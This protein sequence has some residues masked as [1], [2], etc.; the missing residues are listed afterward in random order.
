[1]DR[2]VGQP[3]EQTVDDAAVDIESQVCPSFLG[4][5]NKFEV[6]FKP[7]NKVYTSV[8]GNDF[9]LYGWDKIPKLALENPAIEF[10][11]Y[12]NSKQWDLE[13]TV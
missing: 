1:M 8:S 11:L 5:V 13:L 9:K 10:H 12:G 7:G 3:V 6:S 4:D 2:S